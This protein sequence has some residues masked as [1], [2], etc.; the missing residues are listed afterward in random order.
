MFVKKIFRLRIWSSR[1]KYDNIFQ[2]E[3]S[4]PNTPE[5]VNVKEKTIKTTTV[6]NV[7]LGVMNVI[8]LG[9]KLD[10]VIDHIKDNRLDLVGITDR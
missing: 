6:T 5:N 7:R 4:K 3:N 2:T 9:S 1:Y 10:C 8:S